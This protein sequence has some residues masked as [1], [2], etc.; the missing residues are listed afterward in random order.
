MQVVARVEHVETALRRV[1]A[2]ERPRSRALAWGMGTETLDRLNQAMI[3]RYTLERPIGQGGMATVYLAD[4]LRHHRKVAIKV[5]RPELAS[6]IGAGRFEREVAVAARLNHPHIVALYDSGQAAGQLYYVMPWI[7]GESLRQRLDREPQ[8]PVTEALT[9]IRQAASA[10]THA[11]QQGLVHRDIK[12]EN[13]LLYE[14]E[15]MVADFGIAL[16][17]DASTDGRLTTA[18]M[19]LGTPYYMSPEQAAGEQALD[20][21]SDIY[22]LACVLFELL[23]GE[24][25]FTGPTA[26]A[27]IARRFSGTVPS[28]RRLRPAAPAGVDAALQRAMSSAPSAR[29]ASCAEFV[30]AFDDPAAAPPRA[31]SVAVL[32]FLNLSRDSE[33]EFFADGITED[34]IAQLSKIRNLKVISRSSAMRFKTREPSLREIGETLGVATLLDGSVRR[35]GDKV[36]I[37]AQLIDAESDEHVWSE[38]YDRQ[39]TDLFAIQSDVALQIA[40]A[41]RAELTPAVQ[42]RIQRKPTESLLAYQYYMQGRHSYSQYTEES[43]TRGIAYYHEAVKLDPRFA[44]AWVGIAFAYAELEAGSGGGGLR[45]DDAHRLGREAADRAIAL[46]PELGEAHSVNALLMMVHDYDWDG[47][48][49]A[50]KRALELN[51]GA[52]EIH[53]HYGWL[54][55]AL[56]RYDEAI[57][58]VKRAQELDPLVHRSDVCSTLIRAGRYEEALEAA[59][60][61]VA[62]AP[63]YGRAHSTRAWACYFLGRFDEAVAGIEHAV[64]LNPGHTLYLGQLGEMYGLTGRTELARDVLE[65]MEQM[66]RERY[67]SHYH[68]AYVLTGLGEYD[69]ALDHLERAYEERGGGLYGMKGSYLFVPLRPDPR[70]QALLRKL[71]LA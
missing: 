51:P 38:T 48:E 42:Q 71:N 44:L 20:A 40:S 58:L 45:P 13:I 64:A 54:C 29:F 26:Q 52:A 63:T 18:G 50:F 46:D 28:V 41:L 49:R 24:P 31:R 6:S 2:V 9:I 22:S 16:V 68:M 5:L 55:G 47:A 21:R 56:E 62:F 30:Q 27:I 53:D 67:V 23:A 69:R 34:V 19:A 35:A 37:V 65:Q 7:R 1:L 12:P 17:A 59:D 61:A 33:N 32:P 14:G 10:L 36:R 3:G 4:D 43:I 8:L 70:F 39:L 15:A 11:H 25:P 60:L 66:A 57:A